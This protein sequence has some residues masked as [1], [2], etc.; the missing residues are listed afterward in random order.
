[1][2]TDNGQ[3]SARELGWIKVVGL[4]IAFAVSG[5]FSGWNLGLGIGGWGGMAVAALVMA[6]FYILLARC[7]AELAGTFP[8]AN[9]MDSYA[10]E[11]LGP[12]GG[13]IAG[14]SVATA[15]SLAVGL[16][17]N[18]IGAYCE[19]VLDVGG[20]TVKGPLLLALIGAQLRG[21]RDAVGFTMVMG[22]LSVFIVIVFCAAAAPHFDT[23]HLHVI[24]NGMPSL[25]RHGIRGVI[26]C[27]PY[28][29]FLFLG[30]EQAANAAGHMG[31]GRRHLPKALFLACAITLCIGFGSLLFGTGIAGV[32][33]LATAGDPLYAAITSHGAYDG[34]SLIGR[35][36]GGGAIVS[37]VGTVFSLAYGASSQ[38]RSLAAGGHLPEFFA[39]TNGRGAPYA[40]L[41]LVGAAAAF[42]SMQEPNVILVVFIFNL[43]VCTQLVLASFLRL[44][45]RRPELARPYWA[46]AGKSS[47][48]AAIAL[49]ALVMWACSELQRVGL[50]YAV[51]GYA[52]SAIYIYLRLRRH[53][54][55]G[56]SE[57]G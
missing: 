42:A 30:V 34:H 16:G 32:D 41:V 13:F 39:R 15:M 18:F 50:A 4:G 25:V 28:A 44:R 12:Y 54:D 21:A 14:M 24:D 56:Q 31:E 29:L 2:K 26:G 57:F 23:E 27:V 35:V 43:N 3:A 9:G 11:G 33:R 10:G 19:S 52:T 5:N 8:S 22:F 53:V 17:I 37:L 46:R 1:V 49:S 45:L 55:A 20:W 47:A 48:V 6:C 7:V 38:F 40:A 51:L 36:I